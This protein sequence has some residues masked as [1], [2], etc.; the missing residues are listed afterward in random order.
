MSFR[1]IITVYSENIV[2]N[3]HKSKSYTLWEKLISLPSLFWK[4]KNPPLLSSECLNQYLW[5]FVCNH[6][7]PISTAYFIN[8]SRQSVCVSHQKFLGKGLIECLS[9]F[10]A[11]QRLGKHVPAAT[12]IRNNRRTVGR[13]CP[14]VYLCIPLSLQGSNSLKTFPWNEELLETSFPMRSVF[15]Q[16]T[17]GD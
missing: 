1:E 9:P 8:P 2:R 6:A 4:K 15:Y 7:K 17:V 3:I 5:K 12:N 13:V 16:M 11:R 14:W 10:T